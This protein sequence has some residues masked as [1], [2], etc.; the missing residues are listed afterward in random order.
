MVWVRPG[1][2]DVFAILL[3]TSELMRL[4]LPTF[5]RPRNATSGSVLAGKRAGSVAE[6]M[7][8]VRTFT[9]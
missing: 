5:E 6:I 2:F 9:K 4:D 8:F 7:N 3:L 1:V